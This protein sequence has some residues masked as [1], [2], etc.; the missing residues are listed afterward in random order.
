M[1]FKGYSQR[2][3][4]ELQQMLFQVRKF[5]DFGLKI[6]QKLAKNWPKNGKK[7]AENWLKNGQNLSKNGPKLG[8]K[9]AENGPKMGRK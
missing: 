2:L 4:R 3:S 7:L 9:W 6:G 5:D 1:D 8:R